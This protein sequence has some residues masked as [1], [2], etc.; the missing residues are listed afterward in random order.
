MEVL[1][2]ELSLEG[3]FTDLNE[4]LNSLR[5]F[6]LIQKIMDAAQIKLLK[7]YNLLNEKVTVSHSLHAVLTDNSIKTTSEIRRFKIYLKRLLSD[8]SFWHEN[9]F[10]KQSDRYTCK[11]T[12]KTH[13][14]SLAEACERDRRV[15]SFE[16]KKFKDNTIVIEKNNAEVMTLLNFHN[17]QSLSEILFEENAINEKDYCDVR[18]V[19][20]NLSFDHLD[21]NFSFGILNYEEKRQFISTFKMFSEMS[22]DDILNHDGLDYK[23]YTPSG[24]SWFENTPFHNT[25]IYK[26]RTSQ[27]LRCFG[28]R[29]EDIF[30]VLRFERDHKISDK[31]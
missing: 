7:H 11:F 22:W 30:Y 15:L 20:T 4:F 16:N 6:I 9:Q 24:Q 10:H 27:K 21:E 12:D 3:Q 26:F 14:Y 17:A 5:E 29:E 19:E 23:P 1:M 28:F 18:F 8:P 31:G 2:N 25:K 13:D